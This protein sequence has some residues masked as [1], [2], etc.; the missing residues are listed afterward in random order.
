MNSFNEFRFKGL[1]AKN[2]DR[3]YFTMKRINSDETKIV[4]RIN[5]REL[6]GTQYG[7]AVIL[8]WSHVIFV[9][10]WQ[11]NR[12][13]F[14]NELLLFKNRFKPREWKTHF[15]F[16]NDPDN[17]EWDA[18]VDRARRQAENIG[19]DGNPDIPVRWRK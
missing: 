11:V 14:G 16:Y 18:W 8:D 7:Y 2:H 10:D 5:D 12:S 6:K 19:K 13:R 4:V 17:L 3:S 15:S 9:K 1:S